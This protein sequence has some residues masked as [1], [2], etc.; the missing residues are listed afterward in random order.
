MHSPSF[1]RTNRVLK[2]FKDRRRFL[3]YTEICGTR[4]LNVRYLA[5]ASFRA[6]I[7]GLFMFTRVDSFWSF[8]AA[9]AF[10]VRRNIPSIFRICA[11][12]VNASNFRC[13]LCRYSVPW[14]F[15]CLVV[16]RNI[17]ALFQIKRSDRL[18]P[19]TQ[20]ASSITNS[21][22]FVLFCGP[23]SRHIMFALNYF[24]MG[25]GSRANFHVKYFN[26]RRGS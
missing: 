1:R 10:V 18:R 24:I 13:T 8:I 21:N 23:P 6:I 25:L 12:L 17:F 16:Y 20:V 14:S 19:I 2:R 15:R 5:K 9:M 11:G 4:Y 22:S 3:S 7:C 26:C